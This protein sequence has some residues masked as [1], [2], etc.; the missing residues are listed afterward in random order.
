MVFDPFAHRIA[1]V[2]LIDKLWT[3]YLQN[4]ELKGEKVLFDFNSGNQHAY[5]IV[6]LNQLVAAGIAKPSPAA[7]YAGSIP[8]PINITFDSTNKRVLVLTKANENGIDKY[9]AVAVATGDN[10]DTAFVNPKTDT[11]SF[12][13]AVAPVVWNVPAETIKGTYKDF[14]FHRLSKTFVIAEEREISG[15]RRTIIQGFTEGSGVKKFQVQ[16]GADISNMAI[17]N[18]DGI[19]YVAENKSSLI[20]SKIKA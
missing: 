4:S 20:A 12:E 11:T 6:N 10:A 15:V 5:T 3:E 13:P 18:T 1:K 16:I 14:N 17:N 9:S 7:F 19:I 8:N 2:T